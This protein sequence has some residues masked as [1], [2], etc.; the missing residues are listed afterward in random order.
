MRLHRAKVRY[1]SRLVLLLF[2][3]SLPVGGTQAADIVK[4]ADMRHHCDAQLMGYGLVTGLNGTGDDFDKSPLTR[5]VVSN[6]LRRQGVYNDPQYHYQLKSKNVALVMVCVHPAPFA[7]FGTV[8]EAKILALRDALD[9]SGGTL[10]PTLLT[11]FDGITYALARGV[12]ATEHEV[13]NKTPASGEFEYIMGRVVQ[14]AVI[15]KLPHS[16]VMTFNNEMKLCLPSP[17]ITTPAFIANIIADHFYQHVVRSWDIGRIWRQPLGNLHYGESCF[18]TLRG[19]HANKSVPIVINKKSGIILLGGDARVSSVTVSRGNI[20]M[21]ITD[22]MIVTQP[23]PLR[24]MPLFD[25]PPAITG[26]VKNEPD[27]LI[28]DTRVST[29]DIAEALYAIGATP[30]DLIAVFMVIMSTGALQG[31]LIVL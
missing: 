24:E 14:G 19:K 25:T 12:V 30:S 13:E 27:P 22:S 16:S 2:L 23:E 8:L 1:L 31:E 3:M 6:M 15:I 9:L 17:S 18:V 10:L 7:P 21:I 4:L 20:N 26:S 5:R 11:G 29:G 28:A